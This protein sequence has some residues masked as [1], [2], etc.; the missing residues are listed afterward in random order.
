MK[1]ENLELKKW[2]LI[3]YESSQE[4]F[5]KTMLNLSDTISRTIS[6]GFTFIQSQ[7]NTKSISSFPVSALI[8]KKV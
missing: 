2:M 1:R 4:Q 3:Q 8:R 7:N 6:E 5:E